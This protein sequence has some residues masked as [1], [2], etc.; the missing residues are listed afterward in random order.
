MLD[1]RTPQNLPERTGR[2]LCIQCMADVET[3]EYL[4][5]DHLCDVCAD[6]TLKDEGERMKDE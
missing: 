4:R 1:D 2:H 6:G 3:E 5:N